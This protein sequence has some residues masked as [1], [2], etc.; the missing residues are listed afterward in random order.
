LKLALRHPE[1]G[2]HPVTSAWT[3]NVPALCEAVHKTPG[4]FGGAF[5]EAYFSHG[6]TIIIQ[7]LPGNS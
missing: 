3:E 4:K 5:T 7:R 2:C 6:E 1:I